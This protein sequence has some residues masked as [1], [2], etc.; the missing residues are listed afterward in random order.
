MKSL[1]LGIPVFNAPDLA[2]TAAAAVP[3]LARTAAA[4][5]FGLV[6]AIFV[7]DGSEPALDLPAAVACE[8]G[9][10]VPIRVLR[11]PVNCGKGA[12]VR[13]FFN[14]TPERKAT[15]HA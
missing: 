1:S 4:C 15:G 6:E 13:A 10:P 5:G 9:P 2:R 12:A 14:R 7:D 11:Q 3:G 8:S